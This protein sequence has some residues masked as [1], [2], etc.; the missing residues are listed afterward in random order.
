MYL[1]VGYMAPGL[2]KYF[3]V[4]KVCDFAQ[5][6][7]QDPLES[8]KKIVFKVSLVGTLKSCPRL[9]DNMQ[10]I[11]NKSFHLGLKTSKNWLKL[12]LNQI[13]SC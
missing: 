3:L 9:P 2:K 13:G 1:Y 8:E 5:K 10:K 11:K 6:D 12:A 7:F 4:I